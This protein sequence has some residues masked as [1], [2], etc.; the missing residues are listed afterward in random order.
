MGKSFKLG[1][2]SLFVVFSFQNCS[3]DFSGSESDLNS[4]GSIV[5]DGSFPIVHSQVFHHHLWKMAGQARIEKS[6][7]QTSKN[8]L[9]GQLN[10]SVQE[11]Q[12]PIIGGFIFVSAL[13]SGDGNID[14]EG[15][16][17][18]ANEIQADGTRYLFC[19]SYEDKDSKLFKCNSMTNP[20]DCQFSFPIGE[21]IRSGQILSLTIG[22][23]TDEPRDNGAETPEFLEVEL[24]DFLK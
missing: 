15:Y 11:D 6:D 12:L 24:R 4:T 20:T 8:T 16:P 5:S 18:P 9:V 2:A 3:R 1:I 14:T 17:C 22:F 19:S 10:L 13:V 21:I 7:A 23:L